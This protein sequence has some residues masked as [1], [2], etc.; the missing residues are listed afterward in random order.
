MCRKTLTVEN[1]LGKMLEETNVG[2][3]QD[4]PKGK[5]DRQSPESG[6]AG[7]GHLHLQSPADKGKRK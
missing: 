7:N 2:T 4:E 6:T 3:Q 5:R 1:V